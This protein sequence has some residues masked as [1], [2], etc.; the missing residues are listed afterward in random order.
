MK[1]TFLLFSLFAITFSIANA[2]VEEK[3]LAD[4]ALKTTVKA[5]AIDSAK[6]WKC[7]GMIG[8][9]GAQTGLFNW[10]AG[11]NNNVTGFVYANVTLSFK[12]NKWTWDSNL[13]TELGEMYSSD[14]RKG[15]R[16]RKANDKINFTTKGGFQMHPQWYL[17]LLGSFKSQYAP[18]K[19]Y[20]DID[21]FVENVTE[22]TLISKWLSPSY[23]DLALGVEY[24]PN[25]IFTVGVYPVAGRLTT[26]LEESLRPNYGMPVVNH[27]DGTVTYKPISA[28]LGLRI[29][30]G[31]NY[32]LVKN[33]KI[34]STVT[35][36]TPYTSKQQKFG[37][38]DVDWDFAITYNFLK[39]FNVS[40]MTSLK[41]YDQ[42]K[43]D[44]PA[45][46]INPIK[47]HEG[48]RA[49]V[50]FKEVVGLG[51]GYSF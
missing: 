29:N 33:L 10:A 11:G 5:A 9:N 44:G 4:Q 22:P 1:K 28:A 47:Y 41:Y 12:K 14:F 50:Q 37:N 21:N 46:D 34:I 39:V 26:C 45:W 30:G 51:I 25:D 35:L 17:T 49:R 48:P 42:V 38:F 13:D 6:H 24:R 19:D 43:I 2:Q 20:K 16:W 40:L 18:G 27:D 15:Y 23:T 36:F 7:T 8:L 31:I 3:A 32:T